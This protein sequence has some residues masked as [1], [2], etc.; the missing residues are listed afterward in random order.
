MRLKPDPFYKIK[1]G[2]KTIELRL[3][4]EKRQRIKEGDIIVFSVTDTTNQSLV[5]R[6]T[7]LYCFD[8]F[9]Q[10]YSTLPMDKCGYKKG[11][12]ANHEDMNKYYTKEDQIEYGAIGI[13]FVLINA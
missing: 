10:L 13:E 7:A 2:L 12:K 9:A 1:N 6:V 4:D 3:Y 8:S 11:E 5:V